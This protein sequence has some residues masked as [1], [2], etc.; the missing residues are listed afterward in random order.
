MP[1]ETQC[2]VQVRTKKLFMLFGT[3][4]NKLYGE[5]ER[6]GEGNGFPQ[7]AVIFN[8][9]DHHYKAKKAYHHGQRILFGQIFFHFSR[10]EDILDF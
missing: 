9:D 7:V 3:V 6:Q 2:G 5:A 4:A 1:A 10:F 8:G